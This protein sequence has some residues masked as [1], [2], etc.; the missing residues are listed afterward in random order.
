MIA[1]FTANG[2]EIGG[3]K[4][5][6]ISGATPL[7]SL[8]AGENVNVMNM[9]TGNIGGTIGETSVI[10]LVAGACLLL[11]LGI[12]DLRIPG[13]YI[14]TFLLFEGIFGGR[15]LAGTETVIN[16]DKGFFLIIFAVAFIGIEHIDESFKAGG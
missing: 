5:D 2:F 4:W 6:A 15:G 16:T 3:L 1:H 14:V 7:A 11:L 8:K 13:S 12:I 10:A 9:I